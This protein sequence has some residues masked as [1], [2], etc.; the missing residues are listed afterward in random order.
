[1]ARNSLLLFLKL[2]SLQYD[3]APIA[4]TSFESLQWVKNPR[5]CMP[6]L[7]H[8]LMEAHK[9][10]PL[11]SQLLFHV[12][13]AH[14]E[15]RGLAVKDLRTGRS[16]GPRPHVP[17]CWRLGLLPLNQIFFLHFRFFSCLRVTLGPLTS[18]TPL[19]SRPLDS[20]AMTY[21]QCVLLHGVVSF[22]WLVPF[23]NLC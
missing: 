16:L 14:C 12:R 21:E 10:G 7:F 2:E 9:C 13:L 5:P 11:S 18:F 19:R 8:R 22:Y 23:T 1:M 20:F 4:V 15:K 6:T 3:E 17:A